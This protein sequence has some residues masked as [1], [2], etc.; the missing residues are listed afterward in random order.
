MGTILYLQDIYHIQWISHFCMSYLFVVRALFMKIYG[1][2]YAFILFQE[3]D[4]L[5][6]VDQNY[7]FQ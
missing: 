7:G 1:N 2:F 3:R 5:L 4:L 6:R